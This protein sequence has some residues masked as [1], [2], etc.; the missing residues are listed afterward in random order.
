MSEFKETVGELFNLQGNKFFRT[1]RG[2]TIAP[3]DTIRAFA[4]G[5][6]KSFLHPFTYAITIIGVSLFLSSFLNTGYDYNSKRYAEN[7]QEI[8]LLTNKDELS[9]RE[10]GQLEIDNN[11]KD[12]SEFQQTEAF[13]RIINY[14]LLFMVSL[15][16]L[17]VFKNLNFG[18]KKNT[19]YNFYVFGNSILISLPIMIFYFFLDDD[20]L[21][22]VLIIGIISFLLGLGYQI[23]AASQYYEISFLRAFKKHLFI[24]IILIIFFFLVFFIITIVWAAYIYMTVN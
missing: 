20:D 8:E 4:A 5:D 13:K 7:E 18:L 24:Y 3:G 6:R 1:I 22:F 19:W 17:L 14:M 21:Y 16:H 15:I 12:F 9:K 23:W 10:K 2:L 11:M